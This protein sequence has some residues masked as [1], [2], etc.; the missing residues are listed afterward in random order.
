MPS[1][2]VVDAKLTHEDGAWTF[3]AG[4]RNLLNEK[5][6]TYGVYTGFPTFAALPASERA[7]FVSAQHIFR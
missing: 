1:Y 3:N 5:Y 4:V 6:Y 7:F 2:T